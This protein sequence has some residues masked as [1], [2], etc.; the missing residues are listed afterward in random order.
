MGCVCQLYHHSHH[1]MLC[2]FTRLE[3]YLICENFKLLKSL[4]YIV[5]ELLSGHWENSGVR[6]KMLPIEQKTA[7]NLKV[8]WD[9]E[10][11][12]LQLIVNLIE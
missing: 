9:F 3:N 8:L 6:K 2:H 11:E 7:T 4:I 1:Y 12:H 10:G 5:P